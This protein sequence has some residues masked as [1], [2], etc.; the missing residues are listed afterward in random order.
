MLRAISFD[1]SSASVRSSYCNV[2][3]IQQ[4][5][6]SERQIVRFTNRV[7]LLPGELDAAQHLLAQA[8][9]GVR[10]YILL[11]YR[12]TARL[13]D[14]GA[15]RFYLIKSSANYG[16]LNSI[17]RHRTNTEFITGNWDDLLRARPARSSSAL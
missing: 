11:G 15:T 8:I 7:L 16:P 10:L 17:A 5:A 12:F 2:E 9:R 6:Q 3:G 14:L 4:H 1:G 13:A